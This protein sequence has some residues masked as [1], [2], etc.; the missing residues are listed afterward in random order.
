MTK[1]I[2]YFVSYTRKDKRLVDAFLNLLQPRLAIAQEFSFRRWMDRDIIIGVEWRPQ[3][4]SAIEES[5]LGLLL[6]SP[7]FFANDFIVDEELAQYINPTT[8]RIQRALVPVLLKPVPLD[9]TAN[10]RGLNEIQIYRE[11]DGRAFSETAGAKRDAFVDGFVR[12]LIQ[13]LNHGAR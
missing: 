7:D 2:N 13:K 1:A 6:V 3:I 12:K 4:R 10:L 5:D 11:D 8:G 9:G